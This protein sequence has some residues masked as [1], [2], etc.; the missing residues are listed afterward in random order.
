MS[1]TGKP[2]KSLTFQ[3]TGTA[4]TNPDMARAHLVSWEPGVLCTRVFKGLK[5]SSVELHTQGRKGWSKGEPAPWSLLP[6]WRLV[7]E[8]ALTVFGNL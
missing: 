4:F 7:R 1:R 5:N 2:I 3:G 8:E 6:T